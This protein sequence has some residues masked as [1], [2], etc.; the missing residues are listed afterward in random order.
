MKALVL[1]FLLSFITCNASCSGANQKQRTL[2]VA[3]TSVDAARDSFITWDAAHQSDI[4]GTVSSYEEGVSRLTAY[5]GK[6]DE[7]VAGFELAYQAIAAAALGREDITVENVI[8]RV[9]WLQA[10]LDDL[11]R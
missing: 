10:A 5:R 1:G 11:M 4:V 3:L 8:E 6:R 2:A 7:I 9:R